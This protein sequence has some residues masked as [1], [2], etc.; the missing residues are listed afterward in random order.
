MQNN[1]LN[2]SRPSISVMGAKYASSVQHAQQ[3]YNFTN[4]YLK[5]NF[6]LAVTIF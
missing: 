4:N 1:K 6:L 3:V 2:Y 5:I